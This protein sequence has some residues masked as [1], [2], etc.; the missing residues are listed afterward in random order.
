MLLHSKSTSRF[1]TSRRLYAELKTVKF[2][3]LASVR[4]TWYSVRMLICQ[5]ASVRTTST[6]WPDSHLC[7]EAS[8][9]SRLHPFRRLSNTSGRLLVCSI[10]KM[11]SFPNT[12]MGRQLQ[13]S[14][15]WRIPSTQKGHP[16]EGERKGEKEQEKKKSSLFRS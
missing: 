5:A 1:R 8:N 13:P 9:C 6:F 14:R 12:D 4:T 7:P 11:I 10:S 16:S 3:S 15:R 2:K